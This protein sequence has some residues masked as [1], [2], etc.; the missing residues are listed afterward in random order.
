MAKDIKILDLVQQTRTDGSVEN[1]FTGTVNGDKYSSTYLTD[2]NENP[3]LTYL[4][5][6]AKVLNTLKKL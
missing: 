3:H 2:G 1:S 5:W 6:K 4:E